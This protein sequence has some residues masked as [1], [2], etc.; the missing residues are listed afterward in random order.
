M[1]TAD[2]VL[3]AVIQNTDHIALLGPFIAP[4]LRKWEEFLD[5]AFYAIIS[6]VPDACTPQE[7]GQL[8]QLEKHVKQAEQSL[9]AEYEATPRT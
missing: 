3:N 7:I 2:Q 9:A 5:T 1:E 8:D 4:I 6:I